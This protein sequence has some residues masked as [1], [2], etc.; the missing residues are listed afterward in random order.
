MSNI[1]TLI[2]SCIKMSI[3]MSTCSLLTGPASFS[4]S[5]KLLFI[6]I[7]SKPSHGVHDHGSF[8]L[9][10]TQHWQSEGNPTK[11][12][13]FCGFLEFL[14]DRTGFLPDSVG[15]LLSRYG[16]LMD[17]FGLLWIPLDC[18]GLRWILRAIQKN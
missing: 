18:C 2:G 9:V 12:I 6:I 10:R 5:Q 13:R 16:F 4:G 7:K 11:P 14:M 8:F 17:C 3:C 15:F 1:D